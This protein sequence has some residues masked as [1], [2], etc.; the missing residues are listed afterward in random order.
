VQDCPLSKAEKA[1]LDVEINPELF[2]WSC[3]G[4][5][6]DD[7]GCREIDFHHPDRGMGY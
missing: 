6:A 3:C 4:E 1:K 2:V 5:P 7:P